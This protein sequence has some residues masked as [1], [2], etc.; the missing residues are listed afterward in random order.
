VRLSETALS[1]TRPAPLPPQASCTGEAS[2]FIPPKD[3]PSR[4]GSNIRP[5]SVGTLANVRSKGPLAN[6]GRSRSFRF[7]IRGSEKR[8]ASSESQ[9]HSI[10]LIYPVWSGEVHM[11]NFWAN[12]PP[13]DSTPTPHPVAANNFAKVG[14][15]GPLA[16][17]IF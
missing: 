12:C 17:S 15:R 7:D 10:S 2:S 3:R 8:L 13:H 16:N 9:I 1:A 5:F 6:L 4:S 14:K 11:P